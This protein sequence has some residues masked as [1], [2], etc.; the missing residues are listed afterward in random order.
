MDL[1]RPFHSTDRNEISGISQNDLRM[2]I[3]KE[4]S[5]G[6]CI[7]KNGRVMHSEKADLRPICDG[8]HT[9]NV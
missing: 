5:N 8:T 9:G 2:L 3:P 7:R 4:R 1:K 6:T